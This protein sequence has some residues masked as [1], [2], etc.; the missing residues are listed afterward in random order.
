LKCFKIFYLTDWNAVEEA[1]IC[2]TC[3]KSNIIL[4]VNYE[5]NLPIFGKLFWIVRPQNARELYFFFLLSRARARARVCVC[6]IEIKCVIKIK[7]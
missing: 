1:V 6:V 5:E 7:I 4:V 2:G 3:Y